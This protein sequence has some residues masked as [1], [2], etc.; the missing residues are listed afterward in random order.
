MSNI[1]TQTTKK[2]PQPLEKANP[3]DWTKGKPVSKPFSKDLEAKMDEYLKEI[4]A[5]SPP[6]KYFKMGEEEV[7]V[8]FEMD[9][10]RVGMTERIINDKNGNEIPVKKFRFILYNCKLGCEQE[11]EASKTASTDAITKMKYYGNNN[12]IIKRTGL[13][14][15]DTKYDFLPVMLKKAA[16]L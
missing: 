3:M 11:W 5:S 15:T 10:P 16:E 13:G 9:D 8:Y 1:S 2:I 14:L 12:L 7:E 6:S 4:E